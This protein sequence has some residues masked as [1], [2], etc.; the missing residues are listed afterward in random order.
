[1]KNE[2]YNVKTTDATIMV[3]CKCPT[4]GKHGA[5]LIK[6]PVELKTHSILALRA[7][8]PKTVHKMFKKIFGEGSG[9]L[10]IIKK[11]GGL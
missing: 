10:Q 7:L 1:M 6:L 8:S 2:Y 11:F 4:I 5:V 3:S 9:P